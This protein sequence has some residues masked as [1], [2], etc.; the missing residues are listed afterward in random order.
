MTFPA[1]Q[2][3]SSGTASSTSSLSGTV[4]LP[5][6]IQIGD[7]LVIA[8]QLFSVTASVCSATGW[9]AA[10]NSNDVSVLWRIADGTEGATVTINWTA[11]ANRQNFFAYRI[12]GADNSQAPA[13][14]SNALATNTSIPAPSLTPS[15]GSA[16]TLWMTF[17]AQSGANTVS[18]YPLT[19]NQ[20]QVINSGN[21][22][23]RMDG[24]TQNIT[25]AT[26]SPS[27]WTLSA[28]SSTVAFTV[29][30]KPAAA[31]AAQGNML[32]VF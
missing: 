4:T 8:A 1:I 3:S 12:T 11:G 16:D 2:T 31:V 20:V 29:G 25:T 5:T 19:G 6:G 9:T 26:E 27:N 23:C 21:T 7:Y 18:A 24:C 32:D 14:V 13:V 30:I 10:H 15:W 17:A 22:N 28:S